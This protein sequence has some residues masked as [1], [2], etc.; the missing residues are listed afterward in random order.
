ML[1]KEPDR[2]EVLSRFVADLSGSDEQLLRDL[3]GDGG[4]EAG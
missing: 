1:D 3:L 4:Q 2:Q